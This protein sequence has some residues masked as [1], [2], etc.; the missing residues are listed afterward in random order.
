[1]R[2]GGWGKVER[3]GQGSIRGKKRKGG[4]WTAAA[5]EHQMVKRDL[6][7]FFYK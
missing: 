5:R 4:I 3:R 2:A 6:K 7:G 1:M